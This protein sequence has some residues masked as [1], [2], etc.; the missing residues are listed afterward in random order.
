MEGLT[1]AE[2]EGVIIVGVSLGGTPSFIP[3]SYFADALGWKKCVAL[4]SATIVC[5]SIIQ[6]A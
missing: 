6:A 5:A 1:T 3:A 2:D 4:R